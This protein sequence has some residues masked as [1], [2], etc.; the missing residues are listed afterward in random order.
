MAIRE[1][2]IETAEYAELLAQYESEI[3]NLEDTPA[4]RP[5]RQ[6]LEQR[7]A[8]L[9]I[10]TDMQAQRRRLQ[11][12]AQAATAA[13]GALGERLAEVARARQY[14]IVGRLTTSTLFDGTRLPR[15]FR[16]QA[17][18]GSMTRTLAYI[19]PEAVRDLDRKVGQIVGVIGT[20]AIDPSLQLNIITPTRVDVLEAAPAPA[21]AG[22]GG[23]G[24]S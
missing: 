5:L 10:L 11:A 20:Q 13:Q 15:M 18:G 16:V 23:R 9:K 17:I 7:Q 1:Q 2:P 22:A 24:G 19:R 3:S 8:F 14:T 12:D 6:R 21:P 4:N